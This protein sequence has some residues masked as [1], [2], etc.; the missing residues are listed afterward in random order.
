VAPSQPVD[1]IQ[2]LLWHGNVE[3]A[4]ER[5]GNLLLDLDLIR[6]HSAPEE[7][8]SAGLAEFETYMQPSGIYPQLR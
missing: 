2:H 6:K 4:L 3:E 5:M 8:L 7:K 1:S